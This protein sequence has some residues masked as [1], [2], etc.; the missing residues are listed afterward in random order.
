MGGVG[1]ADQRHE[2]RQLGY[3]RRGA[4]YELNATAASILGFL[5]RQSMSGS[6]LAAQ[7]ENV[8]GDL[9]NVTRSQVYRELKL[10]NDR[11]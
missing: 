7:I 5:D 11:A 4:E 9:W 6:E 2:R 1:D 3:G 8:I 10:L